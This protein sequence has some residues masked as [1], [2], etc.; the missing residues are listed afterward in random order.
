MTNYTIFWQVYILTKAEGGDGRPFTNDYQVQ[1]F[2][3]TWDCP[4]MVHMPEGKDMVMPGE[5]VTLTATLK[6]DMV[7]VPTSFK[8]P[9][10]WGNSTF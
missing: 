8:R 1:V 5:D 9:S 7:S 10:V 6:K 4:V 3:K 2:C